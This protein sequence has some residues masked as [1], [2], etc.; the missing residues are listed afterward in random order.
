MKVKSY[1]DGSVGKVEVDE[2]AFGEKVLYR[3][4]TVPDAVIS[5]YPTVVS[6]VKAQ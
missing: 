6:V 3:T 5:P 1:K 4:T 2:A